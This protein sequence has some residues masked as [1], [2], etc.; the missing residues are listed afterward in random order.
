MHARRLSLAATMAL[1][2]S[3]AISG[4]SHAAEKIQ[5]GIG[6]EFVQY[7]GY[8]ENDTN[9]GD[10]DGFDV[11]SDGVLEFAGETTL[12]NG[13]MFGVTVG[14]FTY[15]DT[16]DQIDDS[17]L[18]SEGNFGRVEI[19]DRDNAAALMHYAA[20]DVGF[21]VND[22]DVSDWVVNLTGANE[23]SVFQS[24][25][26]YLGEDKAT[27]ISYFTPRIEGF[28]FGASF[29]PEFERNSNVQPSDDLYNSGMAFGMNYVNSFGDVEL[30]LSAGYLRADKPD[31][32]ATGIE[33]AEGYSFGGNIGYAGFTFGGSYADTQGNGSGG[34]D[35]AV[36]FDGRGF[37]VGAAYA[38]GDA[39]VSLSYYR[40][41]VADSA[42]AGDSKH[43]TIMLSGAYDL[44]PGVTATASIFRS[45][46]EADN[47]ADNEGW[48]AISGIVL[49]F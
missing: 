18:Y 29:I 46:F 12:D 20:P 39:Q 49:S 4:T 13:L 26:L 47:G 37:D 34:T 2:T 27:K 8:A 32:A 41:E 44:G 11:Y 14:L 16:E 22:S 10:F 40:G 5:I 35:S 45:K 19:G 33:D 21:G 31:N 6:G 48:A 1:L 43:E 30:A 23:D 9:T 38:F 25:Y 42:A 3:T 28:Q 15:T 24:T 36:S 17:Y 7:F